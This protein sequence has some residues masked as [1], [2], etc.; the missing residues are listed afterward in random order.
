MQQ[1]AGI[2]YST[3]ERCKNKRNVSEMVEYNNNYYR[4]KEHVPQI[5]SNR[6]VKNLFDHGVVVNMTTYHVEDYVYDGSEEYF[7][8]FEK[9][10]KETYSAIYEE[11][12]NIISYLKLLKSEKIHNNQI[13]ATKQLKR[14][15]L[16]DD[17]RPKKKRRIE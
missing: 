12:D 16:D 1:C 4:R 9:K 10:V 2:A 8:E 15:I 5:A 14:K 11:I 6:N 3:G 17:S 13:C 7:D